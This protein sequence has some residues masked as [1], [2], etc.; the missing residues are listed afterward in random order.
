MNM[1]IAWIEAWIEAKE[2]EKEAIE[3]RRKIENE[4]ID[5]LQIPETLDGTRSFEDSGYKVKVTGRMNQKIDADKLQDIAYENGIHE[6]LGDLFRWKPEINARAWKAASE[7][8]TKPLNEA[9]TTTPGR[10]SFHIEPKEEQ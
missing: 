2:T 8:I 1:Y 10:P 7:S 4:L 9:I 3:E 6:H 5:E